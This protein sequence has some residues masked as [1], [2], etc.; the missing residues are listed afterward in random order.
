[1]L[2]KAGQ[3]LE[4]LIITSQ[5]LDFILRSGEDYKEVSQKGQP[6]QNCLRR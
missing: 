6:D 4:G 5:Y 1:M 3:D 2:E